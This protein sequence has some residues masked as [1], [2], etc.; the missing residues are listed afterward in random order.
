MAEYNPSGKIK[1]VSGGNLKHPGSCFSCGSAARPV[2]AQIGFVEYDGTVYLCEYCVLAAMTVFEGLMVPADEKALR[3]EINKV[4]GMNAR[5][6]AKI[7]ELERTLE[8]Y[9]SVFTHTGIRNPSSSGNGASAS[10][11]PNPNDR[12]HVDEV[13]GFSGE[14]DLDTKSDFGAG[15]RD[16]SEL[17]AT[18]AGISVAD[19]K[20][21]SESDG[22]SGKP[23]NGQG[24]N[25][26]SGSRRAPSTG[27][28]L[29]SL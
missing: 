25:R 1:R 11:P 18:A 14:S 22:D 13:P 9:K 10:P 16:V 17:V 23:S 3:D 8:S 15:P 19:N 27:E 7:K 2:Y 5:Q 6:A 20:A 26:R 29:G 24:R 12:I 4:E 28:E 21:A